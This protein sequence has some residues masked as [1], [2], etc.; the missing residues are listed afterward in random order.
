MA[1]SHVTVLSA[2][3][4]IPF[5]ILAWTL[6]APSQE[7]NAALSGTAKPGE[8]RYLNSDPQATR[9]SPLDQINKDNF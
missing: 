5:A 4:S 8:W 9:Y 7:T 3:L 1:R 2:L 6:P